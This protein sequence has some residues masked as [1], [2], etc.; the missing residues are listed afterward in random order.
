[1]AGGWQAKQHA[2]RGLSR[3]GK[4][5]S[6]GVASPR[7]FQRRDSGE[8]A[9]RRYLWQRHDD[10][11][12]GNILAQC[13]RVF[14]DMKYY[15]NH[16]LVDRLLKARLAVTA[17]MPNPPASDHVGLVRDHLNGVVPHYRT[18]RETLAE[19]GGI[20]TLACRLS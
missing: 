8:G 20:L 2:G 17:L 18:V 11:R 15:Q 12:M 3:K 7:A 16:L 9:I 6:P 1:M 5:S 19:I 14:W 13:H 10:L 4:Y